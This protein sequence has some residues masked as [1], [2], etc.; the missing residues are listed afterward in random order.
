MKLTQ[1]YIE[2]KI[3]LFEDFAKFRWSSGMMSPVYCDH[4]QLLGSPRFRTPV[5]Q[6]LV[7]KC[8]TFQGKVDAVVGVATGGIPY[9]TW[10]ASAMDLPLGY[11]RPQAKAHGKQARVE[12]GLDPRA[13]VL[14]VEDMISTGGSSLE[15]VKSLKAEGFQVPHVQALMT[16]FPKFIYNKFADENAPFS[17]LLEF[18][19]FLEEPSV[20]AVIQRNPDL[21]AQWETELEDRCINPVIPEHHLPRTPGAGFKRK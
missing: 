1:I 14:L 12:G 18:K 19:D 11:V 7:E 3:I 5:V 4:R 10:V 2:S 15:V 20:K 13:R 6:A 8:M 9:A 21:Y 16:Y 17:A